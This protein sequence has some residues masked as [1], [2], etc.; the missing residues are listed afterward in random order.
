[1]RKKVNNFSGNIPTWLDLAELKIDYYTQFIKSWI[2]FNAWYTIS[3]HSETLHN[4]R[5]II[6]TIKNTSNPFRDRLINLIRGQDNESKDFRYMIAQLYLQLEAHSIPNHD[7]RIN[8]SSINISRNSQTQASD[9]HRNLHYKVDFNIS[10]PKT[11]KR[12]KCEIFDGSRAMRNIYLD[13]FH[14]WSM[15]ELLNS[16][17]YMALSPE[18]REKLRLCYEEI[19]PFKPV[20]VVLKPIVDRRSGKYS[21]PSSRCI[22][23]DADNHIYFIEDPETI[24]KVIIEI[25]YLLRCALFHGEINPTLTNQVVYEKAFNILK[26]LIQELK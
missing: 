21:K 10:A 1:M 4:D 2:P 3:Y 15:D 16:P 6:D 20:N 9:N 17:K 8:F 19:N 26:V 14:D 13:E 12:L 7:Y 11:T 5:L 24:S 22:V 23:I 18:R 25:L